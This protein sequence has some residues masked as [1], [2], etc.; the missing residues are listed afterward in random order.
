[1]SSSVWA[2]ETRPLLQGARLTM[3]ELREAGVR[4]DSPVAERVAHGLKGAASNFGAKRVVEASHLIEK[5]G[6][7]AKLQDFDECFNALK[8]AL[9]AL[10]VELEALLAS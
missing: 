7:E 10:E 6:R 5:M 3:F 4:G 1:M 9:A 8:T 2:D